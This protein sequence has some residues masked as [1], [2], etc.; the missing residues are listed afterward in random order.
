VQPSVNNGLSPLVEACLDLPISRNLL[1]QNFKLSTIRRCWEDQL[2]SKSNIK[3]IFISK[4]ITLFLFLFS[5]D[6]FPTDADLLVACMI[7]EKQIEL[8]A[9]EGKNIIIPSEHIKKL[10][11]L[12]P[13]NPCLLCSV[14]EKRLACIPCGHYTTCV[15]CSH[16]LRSCPICRKEVHA[17]VNI[18]I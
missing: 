4:S 8:G 5:D 9:E 16:S 15:S 12:F 7:I 18:Y 11:N 2:K 10:N 3:S 13:S 6:D 1:A 17:F 14:E